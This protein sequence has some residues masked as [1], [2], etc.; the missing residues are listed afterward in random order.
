MQTASEE[1]SGRKD[2]IDK[3]PKIKWELMQRNADVT[4]TVAQHALLVKG[5]CCSFFALNNWLTCSVLQ[6][7]RSPFLLQASKGS[8][9]TVALEIFV[10]KI[11]SWFVRT[12]KRKNMKYIL[13]RIIMSTKNS[14]TC[15]E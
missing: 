9:C 8:T 5:G 12:A 6:S 15:I 11:I 1:S 2:T 10:V 3:P 14:N 13:Q 4:N 7:K